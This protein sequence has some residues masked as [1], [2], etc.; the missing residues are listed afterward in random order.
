MDA[1]VGADQAVQGFVMGRLEALS[2]HGA[3]VFEVYPAIGHKISCH[4]GVELKPRVIAAIDHS[5]RVGL[6]TF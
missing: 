3:G 2:L 5:V 1:I 6:V 4:F